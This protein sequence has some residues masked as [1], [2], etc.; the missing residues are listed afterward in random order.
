M[1]LVKTKLPPVLDTHTFLKKS[2]FKIGKEPAWLHS[3]E[4]YQ[5]T[6]KND[7]PPKHKEKT[8]LAKKP[9]AATIFQKD[10]DCT[11]EECSVS[12][13]QFI[14][15]DVARSKAC[16]SLNKTN[17][18][19]DKDRRIETFQTTQAASYKPTKIVGRKLQSPGEAM[20]SRIPDGDREKVGWPPSDYTTRFTAKPIQ[21]GSL[22]R[23]PNTQY[24]TT[25]QGDLRSHCGNDVYR[26]STNIMYPPKECPPKCK[27]PES[28][29]YP[30]TSIPCGDEQTFVS[31][32]STSF[33]GKFP[34]D[35]EPFNRPKA[36][37]ALQKTTFV[38]GDQ[39][40]DSFATTTNQS[41]PY[42]PLDLSRG[43]LEKGKRFYN[44]ITMPATSM[45]STATSDYVAPPSSYRNHIIDGSNNHTSS[46]VSLGNDKQ[47]Y[48][49]TTVQRYFPPKQKQSFQKLRHINTCASDIPMHYYNTLYSKSSYSTDFSPSSPS[50]KLELNENALQNLQKSH[51]VE[52]LKGFSEFKTTHNRFFTP[53]KI[54]PHPPLSIGFLQKSSVPIGTMTVVE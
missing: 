14:K 53:K 43:I 5:S 1:R 37:E 7:Y 26:T 36:L 54:T 32:Q 47:K 41:H 31:T 44:S 16:K 13:E 21:P 46:D 52:P 15:K 2:H 4:S 33:Q 9:P 29:K 24:S 12:H 50:K 35:S 38:S 3:D 49:T 6:C 39:R 30:S 18:K 11:F 28:V 25:I 17:F 45:I 40:L 8:G 23:F 27:I 34:S 42:V 20:K 10:I 19:M 48:Y 51:I 22:K